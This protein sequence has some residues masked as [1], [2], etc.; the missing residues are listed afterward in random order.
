MAKST[1]ADLCGILNVDK[2]AGPTSH[3]VVVSIRRMARQRKV[4]HA[5]TLDPMA[6]G[7]LLVCLGRATRVSEYLMRSAKV[8]RAAIRFGITTTT[9]D[10]EGEVTGVSRVDV[11][12]SHLDAALPQF[13]GRI[14]QVPPQYS[15]IKRGGKRLY[16]LARQGV[17]VDVPA[18]E[19]DIYRLQI[20]EWAPPVLHLEVHCGPGTY[21][22]ALARDL[23][24]AMGCGA[25]LSALRRL[26]S[27][28][29]AA[30]DAVTLACLES[31]FAEGT[32]DRHLHPPDVAFD[33]LPAVHLDLDAARRLA[34]GQ[35]V[36]GDIQGVEPGHGG[37]ARSYAPSGQ[38]VALVYRD[39]QSGAWRPRKVFVEPQA[40]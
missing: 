9:Q 18:R 17:H 16:E 37:L 1:G 6:T 12:R 26:S 27:G 10:A 39:E 7:V 15:A 19:V 34:M 5:G 23:G 32:I 30:S 28:S 8:Y 4:G 13:Q 14:R 21:V 2:P 33:N 20:V 24:Q 31:A 11:T 29:F 25:H 35:A 38:F 40:I 3:D 22:R 36:E